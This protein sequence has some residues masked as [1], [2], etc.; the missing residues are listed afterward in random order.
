MS[1]SATYGRKDS[2]PR[3]LADFN[4]LPGNTAAQNRQGFLDA[5]N[6]GYVDFV[7]PPG[8]YQWAAASNGQWMMTFAGKKHIR[9]RGIDAVINDTTAYGNNGPLEGVFLFD[10]CKDVEVSGIEYVGPAL[11]DPSTLLGY[12]GAILVRAI[13]GTDGVKVDMRATNCRYGVQTGDYSD[14]AKGGC[15]NFDVK[16]RGTMIGYGIAAHRA[17]GIRHDLDVDGVHRV[18]YMAGCVD[19]KGVA[20]WRNQY[21]APIAYLLTDCITSGTDTAAQADPVNSPTTSRGCTDVKV[22]VIDKG[23]IVFK[24]NSMCAGINLSRVDPCRF[25][26]ID[27]TVYTVGTDTVSTKVGGFI[28]NSTGVPA[29]WSRYTYNWESTV[30][31]DNV[32][33]SG[34]VD[35]SAQTVASNTTGELYIYT[36]D[37]AG[38]ASGKYATVRGLTVDGLTILKS[39]AASPRPVVIVA[40]EPALPILLRNLNAPGL[41]VSLYTSNTVTTK[42]DGCI[43][44]SVDASSFSG[45]ALFTVGAGCNIAHAPGHCRS[46]PRVTPASAVQAGSSPRRKL[47]S[48]CQGRLLLGRQLFQEGPCCWGCRAGYRPRSPAPPVFR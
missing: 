34:V 14:P 43:L 31:F 2:A 26:N 33:I 35:H 13:N 40:R 28:L 36:K 5:Q 10:N 11:S 20:R 44:A 3:S 42:F 7:L 32:K 4:V 17:D 29:V 22:S 8:T 25:E 18:G 39:S 12:Q 6:S 47:P 19:V 30:I 23:S 1:L 37:D 41:T 16:I 48:P 46:A 15:K 21:I 24:N 9:V 38:E 27:I 45:G